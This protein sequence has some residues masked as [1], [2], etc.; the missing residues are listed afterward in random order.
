MIIEVYEEDRGGW[1]DLTGFQE[2]FINEAS[3]RLLFNVK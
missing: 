3:Y 2:W 1:G